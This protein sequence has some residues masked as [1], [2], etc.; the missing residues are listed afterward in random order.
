M[1]HHYSR[2]SSARRRGPTIDWLDEFG[3]EAGTPQP[4]A[5]GLS[6]SG[7]ETLSLFDIVEAEL[8]PFGAREPRAQR[9]PRRMA[10]V[11]IAGILCSG[12]LAGAGQLASA[13]GRRAR[14]PAPVPSSAPASGLAALALAPAPA[15]MAADAPAVNNVPAVYE[16]VSMATVQPPVAPDTAGVDIGQFRHALDTL[17]ARDSGLEHCDLRVTS[18]ERAVAL[19]RTSSGQ[20]STWA[21][22]LSRSEADWLPAP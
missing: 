21:L 8:T 6:R 11:A 4:P 12:V 2:H 16:I 17:I 15:L 3:R 5:R 19:C 1:K 14:V 13:S 20:R 9:T 18:A 10:A 22:D 7:T